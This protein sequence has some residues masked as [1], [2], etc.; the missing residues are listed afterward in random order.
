MLPTISFEL[1][2]FVSPKDHALAVVEKRESHLIILAT[3]CSIESKD[4][5]VLSVILER[6][7]L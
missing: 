1:K 3:D 2:G 7:V 5:G 4:S 6:E